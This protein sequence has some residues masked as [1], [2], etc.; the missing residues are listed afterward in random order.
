MPHWNQRH[1]GLMESC[2]KKNKA[3]KDRAN[4]LIIIKERK[5]NIKMKCTLLAIIAVT[6]TGCAMTD[7]A[8]FKPHDNQSMAASTQVSNDYIISSLK[9]SGVTAVYL[10]LKDIGNHN[11][12]IVAVAS[13]IA[14]KIQ[15]HKINHDGKMVQILNG[16]EVD[17]HS[18]KN[19]DGRKS[20]QSGGYHI[21][22]IGLKS[23]L[24]KGEK[25]PL[26]LVFQDGTEKTI[27]AKAHS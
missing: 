11:D 24:H 7:T 19:L 8:P 2:A 13:P 21:M 15:L 14:R 23:S 27:Y 26:T 22:L 12:T 10:T 9:G 20:I 17:A 18:S 25:V 16:I 1:C 5:M 4:D 6:L 3:S